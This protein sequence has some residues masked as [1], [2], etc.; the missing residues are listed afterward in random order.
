M[1]NKRGMEIIDSLLEGIWQS[2]EW[3]DIL[4]N[5]PMLQRSDAELDELLNQLRGVLPDKQLDK[6]S[7]AVTACKTSAADCALLYGIHIAAAIREASANPRE[8]FQYLIEKLQ[9]KAGAA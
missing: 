2:R 6:L 8:Y 9:K 3:T 1:A 7:D 4:K 5:N